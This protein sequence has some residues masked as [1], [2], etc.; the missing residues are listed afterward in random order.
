MNLAMLRGCAVRRETYFG[1]STF[2][3]ART[4]VPNV[5]KKEGNVTTAYFYDHVSVSDHFS[6]TVTTAETLDELELINTFI[7]LTIF[8]RF[9][10]KHRIRDSNF[11]HALKLYERGISDTDRLFKFFSIF[12]SL[13]VIVNINGESLSGHYLDNAVSNATGLDEAYLRSCRKL[14]NKIKHVQKTDKEIVSLKDGISKLAEMTLS[15][16]KAVQRLIK[17]QLIGIT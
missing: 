2:I 4:D 10:A 15:I 6:A 9:E 5:V 14:Y 1:I 16:R 3:P 12:N 11:V 13:E 7:L 17:L 8:N